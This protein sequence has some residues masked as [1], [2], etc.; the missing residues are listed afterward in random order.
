MNI[1]G[2][3]NIKGLESGLPFASGKSPS[4]K[5]SRSSVLLESYDIVNISI[6]RFS[7]L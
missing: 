2:L 5:G 1:V 3:S 4:I 6:G 7:L